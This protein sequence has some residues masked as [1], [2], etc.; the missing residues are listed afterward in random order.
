MLWKLELPKLDVR[1]PDDPFSEAEL[2]G[3][4]LAGAEL[5]VWEL[6]VWEFI[7]EQGG[8]MSLGA[9]AGLISVLDDPTQASFPT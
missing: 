7:K 2:A 4:E 3:A 6:A 1:K 9:I 5:G 8:M